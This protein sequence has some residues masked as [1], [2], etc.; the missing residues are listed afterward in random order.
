MLHL[1]MTKDLLQQKKKKTHFSVYMKHWMKWLKHRK[2]KIN[3]TRLTTPNV[4]W[5]WNITNNKDNTMK[6]Q[7]IINSKTK[8]WYAK[9]CAFHSDTRHRTLW[10]K[11]TPPYN[12]IDIRKSISF[13]ATF[14]QLQTSPTIAF[15]SILAFKQHISKQQTTV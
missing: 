11:H 15:A 1:A 3:F 6:Q 8:L 10:V 4:R 14:W 13:F 7:N 2:I 12:W 5:R 9:D